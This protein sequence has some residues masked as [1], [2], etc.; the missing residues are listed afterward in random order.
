MALAAANKWVYK[1]KSEQ[2]DSIVGTIAGARL[3]E[4]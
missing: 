3:E 1:G 4:G 2:F